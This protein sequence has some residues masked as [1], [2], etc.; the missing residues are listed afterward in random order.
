[1]ADVLLFVPRDLGF[2]SEGYAA[3]YAAEAGFTIDHRGPVT[4]AFRDD[5]PSSYVLVQKD[6]DKFYWEKER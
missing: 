4:R 2:L 3:D 5:S 6:D 1:M